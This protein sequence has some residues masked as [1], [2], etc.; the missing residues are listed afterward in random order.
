MSIIKRSN[1]K[2]SKSWIPPTKFNEESCNE[3]ILDRPT[4]Y[5][6]QQPNTAPILYKSSTAY[7]E[8]TGQQPVSSLILSFLFFLPSDFLI[9]L[10]EIIYPIAINYLC[11]S[12]VSF[13]L[14]RTSIAFAETIDKGSMIRI[15]KMPNVM[16]RCRKSLK[17]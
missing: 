17:K 11:C 16:T 13:R 15:N 14:E 2:Y 12:V 10:A 1:F 3:Q 4:K 5:A 7:L 9:E 8:N 6:Y